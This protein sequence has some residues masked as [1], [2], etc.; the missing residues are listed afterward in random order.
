MTLDL[1]TLLPGKHDRGCPIGHDQA[2]HGNDRRA[3]TA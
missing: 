3:Q 1:S 2:G